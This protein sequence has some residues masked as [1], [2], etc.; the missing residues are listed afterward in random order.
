[1]PPRKAGLAGA[2]DGQ[3]V[4]SQYR[5]RDL[6][7][8]GHSGLQLLWVADGGPLGVE[9]TAGTAES[10]GWLRCLQQLIQLLLPLTG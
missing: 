4:L 7:R 6:Q 2:L 9:E 3:N 10:R 5:L 1:M 8:A